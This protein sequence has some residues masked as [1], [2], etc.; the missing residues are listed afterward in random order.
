MIFIYTKNTL[1]EEV[2]AIFL[3]TA[4]HYLQQNK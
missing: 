3:R 2:A 4:I 1:Y